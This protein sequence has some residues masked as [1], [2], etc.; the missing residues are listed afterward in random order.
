VTIGVDKFE[1]GAL[2]DKP[3]KL[4]NAGLL[5]ATLFCG[6]QEIIQISMVPATHVIAR[7]KLAAAFIMTALTLRGW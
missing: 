3:S 4:A 7:R 6:E 1:F 5:Q 2:K